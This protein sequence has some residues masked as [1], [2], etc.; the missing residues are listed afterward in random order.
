VPNVNELGSIVEHACT[1]APLINTTQFL[2][3]DPALLANIFWTSSPFVGI[4]SLAWAVNFLAG[5]DDYLPRVDSYM[6]RLVRGGDA[7]TKFNGALPYTVTPNAGA[8]GSFTSNLVQTVAAGGTASLTVVPNPGY[9]VTAVTADT[10]GP[11]TASAGGTYTTAAVNSNC[12]VTASFAPI[13]AATPVPT[14][15]GWMTLVLGG[16]LL[17]I[18]LGRLPRQY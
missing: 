13:V 3:T 16:I 14:L 4:P 6:L 17:L 9:R 8:G 5:P 7:P 18:G 15:S 11:M 10:C 2:A 1:A 12:I